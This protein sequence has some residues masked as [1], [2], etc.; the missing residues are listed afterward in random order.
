ML[1]STFPYES[2]L[3]PA[4]SVH[5]ETDLLAFV[6]FN[7]GCKKGSDECRF[8]CALIMKLRSSAEL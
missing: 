7:L 3:F 8:C 2:I 5:E 6:G 1:R 4:F